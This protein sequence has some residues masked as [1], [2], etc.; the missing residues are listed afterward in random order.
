M[1]LQFTKGEREMQRLMSLAAASVLLWGLA[2]TH[3]LATEQQPDQQ[4]ALDGLRE[5]IQ[6]V[7]DGD[8]AAAI[9]VLEAA[10]IALE[11]DRAA[12]SE[13]ARSYF[14]A[15]V[16]R[17]FIVGDDEARFAFHEAQQHDPQFRPTA[18]QFPRRVIRLWEE[19]STME[20]EAE[21]LAGD[22]TA[23][24]L[25]VITEPAAATVYVA[26]RPRG[27]TPV[28]VVG[29][30]A[31]DQRVTI[32]KDGYINNSR[33]LAL[34]PNS[35][36]R[37]SVELTAAA[38]EGS[39][40]ALQEDSEEGGGSGWWKWAA[41][42]GGGGAAAFLLLPKNKPPI[43][44]A[45]VTPNGS[46][47]AGLTEYRF[48]GSGSSDPDN[49]RLTHMWD[50]GDGSSGSD[51]TTTHVY[52]SAGTYNVTLTVS[53]GKEQATATRSV[54]VTQNLDAG[55]FTTRTYRLTINGRDTGIRFSASSRLTQSGTTLG[56]RIDLRFSGSVPTQTVTRTL[57]GR[58][59]S[60]NN[61]ICPCDV[62]FNV[63]SFYSF[64]GSINNGAPL[65]A[66]TDR[67]SVTN[68]GTFTGPVEYRRQ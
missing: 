63:G 6:M 37:L 24:T 34:A 3:G 59:S 5:G 58:I 10:L 38:A 15:G 25:T 32:V 1:D 51:A 35:A 29:L 44:G 46:G 36:E 27:E 47:M 61:F 50:F 54:T 42:A 52:N 60:S 12:P 20:V 53:D 68:V 30:S 2:D 28:E 57:S 9:E 23:G 33:V 11:A 67:L 13:M 43:A 19:A 62:Q 14:Y 7:E 26:G 17:V 39:A 48:D 56:G 4:P 16:A 40:A 45:N 41:L 49:D 21:S 31:G 55:N 18:D 64:R 65:L 22:E 8:Y 66:G